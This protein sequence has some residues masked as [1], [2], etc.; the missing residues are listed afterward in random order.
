MDDTQR[1]S[2]AVNNINA[3]F[4]NGKFFKQDHMR[5]FTNMSNQVPASLPLYRKMYLRGYIDALMNSLNIICHG[6]FNNTCDCQA[7]RWDGK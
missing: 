6:H 4:G 3:A 2:V 1:Q 7:F 5:L